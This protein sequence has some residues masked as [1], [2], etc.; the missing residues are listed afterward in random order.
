MA[1]YISLLPIV[2]TCAKSA[3]RAHDLL[4]FSAAPPVYCLHE[5]LCQK[6]R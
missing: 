3:Q 2:L 6:S 1:L 4:A 5:E